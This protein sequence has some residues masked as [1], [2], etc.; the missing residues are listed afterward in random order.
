MNL[1]KAR[2]GAMLLAF[3]FASPAAFA[4]FTG[5]FTGYYAPSKWTTVYTN[6]P[7]YQNTA[8]VRRDQGNKLVTITGAVGAQTT[9]QTPA[10]IIDYTIVLDGTGLQPVA[11]GYLFT[12]SADG[13]DKAQLIY[14][15]G[16]GFQVVADLS[17]FTGVQH[18]YVGQLQGGRP[19]GLRVYSNNDNVAD[20]LVISVAP[21]PSTFGLLGLG[22]SALVW[23]L[24]R[25]PS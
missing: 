5:D 14:D 18:A 4:Q 22:A 9:P 21:E 1:T 6:N 2:S 3:L 8:S 17:A 23:R 7:Q 13:Y 25:R 24:R 12:G 19:F 20:T 16:S 15:S 10:S 11:F